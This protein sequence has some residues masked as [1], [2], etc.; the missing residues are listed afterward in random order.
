M[1]G[2]GGDRHGGGMG[3]GSVAR[4]GLETCYVLNF[5]LKNDQ[6]FDK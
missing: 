2:D 1:R 3:A 6:S 5:T 4:A